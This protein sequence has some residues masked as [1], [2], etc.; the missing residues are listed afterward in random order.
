[1]FG[2]VVVEDDGGGEIAELLV[3]AMGLGFET[4]GFH[5]DGAGVPDVGEVG[6]VGFDGLE[7]AGFA[8]LVPGFVQPGD[9]GVC[10]GNVVAGA[11]TMVDCVFLG[12]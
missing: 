12:K 10:D 7:K 8:L 2:V 1:M 9:A 3:G 11:G 6:G 5:V 4:G